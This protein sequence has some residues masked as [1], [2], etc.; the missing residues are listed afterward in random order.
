MLFYKALTKKGVVNYINHW[1][2]EK[3]PSV[4]RKWKIQEDRTEF[5]SRKYCTLNMEYNDVTNLEIIYVIETAGAELW[6]I[7][8]LRTKLTKQGKQNRTNNVIIVMFA[9]EIGCHFLDAT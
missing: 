3:Y 7:L 8:K 4:T 9:I 2:S 1:V 6:I 5:I